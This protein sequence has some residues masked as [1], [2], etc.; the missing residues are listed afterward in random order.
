VLTPFRRPA[1]NRKPV[2]AKVLCPLPWLHR[3]VHTDGT[4]HVCCTADG[5][6]VRR[7]DGRP[8]HIEDHASEAE[9]VN[10]HSMRAM[11]AQM[12]R[13]EWPQACSRCERD[14]QLGAMS[15]R[16]HELRRFGKNFAALAAATASDGTSQPATSFFDY[17]LGNTCN[18]KCRM[19]HPLFSSLWISEYHLVQGQPIRPEEKKHYLGLTWYRD[20]TVF[21]PL[22]DQL[23]HVEHLHFA[24][25]EPLIIP[26]TIALL[27]R[28]VD[29][30]E[31]GHI[32]LNFNTNLTKIPPELRTLWPQFKQVH[33]YCSID[34]YGAVNEYIRNPLKWSEL[35]ANLRHL[36]EEFA[37]YGLSEIAISCTVQAYNVL[38]LGDL[39]DYL[40]TTF[41]NV[42][43]MPALPLLCHPEMFDVRVLTE[44]LK[45]LAI[46]RLE[47]AKAT[48]ATGA[49]KPYAIMIRSVDGIIH[50]LGQDM[51][52]V[53]GHRAR[54]A[55]VTQALDERR[56]ERLLDLIPEMAPMM[57]P[58]LITLRPS[59]L[60]ATAG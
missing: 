60:A 50:A 59:S 39:F 21:R 35:D 58:R 17:R 48:H 1:Q 28:I 34:G 2:A 40:A 23:E 11:K 10:S 16:Q 51:E 38:R 5:G 47:A 26:Q 15:R 13:G 12:M 43:P 19:C 7:E 6:E 53:Q 14:E 36:D 52:D 22:L 56:S 54:F 18:L 41:K 20:E 30:G 44:P 49:W 33:I 46:E 45:R 8:F 32:A 37:D 9:I 25:G 4:I 31:A 42:R 24:G 27:Q 29:R 57:T 55:E 3:Y